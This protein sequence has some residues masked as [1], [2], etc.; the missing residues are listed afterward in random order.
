MNKLLL[1]ILFLAASTTLIFGLSGTNLNRATSF[2]VLASTKV[3]NAGPTGVMGDLGVSPGNT[4]EDN[5]TLSVS[6]I[7][8]L[9]ATAAANAQADA[10][11]LYNELSGITATTIENRL[12][13]IVATAPG[14]YKID[15]NATLSGSLALDG[16]SDVSST[17]IFI[18][19]G[20][21]LSDASAGVF[22][23]NGAQAQNIYWIV[24]GKVHLKNSTVMLGNI[25]AKEEI[26]LENGA[27]LTGRAISLG[28]AVNLN[29]NTVILPELIEAN[30][31]IRKI[32]AKGEY[33]LGDEITYTIVANNA[34]PN[35]ATGVAVQE[36]VPMGLV[37]VSANAE[38]G[39]YDQ[40][41]NRWT[42][43]N[44]ANQETVTLTI[45]FRIS[46]PGTIVNTAHI[47]TDSPDP[48]PDDNSDEAPIDVPCPSGLNITVDG[49][50]NI[51]G[52]GN[53]TYTVTEVAG[54]TYSFEL[55]DGWTIVSQQENSI[56]VSP[57]TASGRVVATVTTK[58]NDQLQAEQAVTVV[59]QEVIPAPTIEGDAVSCGIGSDMTYTATGLD[60]DLTYEWATT[61]SLQIISGQGNETV[62]V[63]TISAD[64]GTL[65]VSA[66]NAC[67]VVS[68]ITTKIITVSN[69]PVAPVAVLGNTDLCAGDEVTYSVVSVEKATSY[70]WTVPSG[71]EVISGQGT[72][73]LVVKPQSSGTIRVTADNS[74]GSSSE[75]STEVTVTSKPAAPVLT[76]DGTPCIGSEVTYAIESPMPDVTYTWAWAGQLTKVKE[77]ATSIT[78]M[79]NGEGTVAVSGANRCG[80]G[81]VTT[82][83]IPGPVGAIGSIQDI[84][85]VCDGL[86]YKV[87]DVPGAG[88]YTWT[89]P[90]GFTIVSGQGTTTIYVNADNNN[91]A[92]EVSV[93]ANN[94]AGCVGSTTARANINTNVANGDLAFPKAFSPNGDNKNDTWFITNL[95]KF[96]DNEVVIFNRWGSEVY[97]QK[98]Y[99]NDWNGGHLEEGT[100]FY[101]VQVMLCE[102]VQKEY[103]GYVTIFR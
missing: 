9:G 64:G 84:S 23:L 66:S 51:C 45:V 86:V 50:S 30:L 102:G 8:D 67:G 60:G 75:A 65:S 94:P 28:G 93:I 101:K 61:G 5:G 56:L 57:G 20:D 73:E 63:R 6:G 69:F 74:C 29:S 79:V 24:K 12:G 4:V 11:T 37:F 19:D 59:N 52:P 83:E 90:A 34:G 43:G 48:D 81:E 17:F 55:P 14:V 53:L 82:V 3:T 71:W 88:S 38:K 18:V 80:T 92:G 68:E 77:T 76:T 35:S 54:A 44:L 41:T 91:A 58:C 40:S 89:V 49:E 21:L 87:E 62:V 99:Q 15:G 42:I 22:T 7:R 16:G 1:L 47:I 70:T 13:G 27:G 78:L 46:E 85:N 10:L 36:N 103:T 25:L 100:Y 95:T 33:E 39:A 98:N 72:P 31:S 96:P 32:A 26:T 97:K 2:A